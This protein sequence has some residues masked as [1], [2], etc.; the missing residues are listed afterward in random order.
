MASLDGILR[1]SD[2]RIQRSDEHLAELENQLFRFERPELIERI[3]TD[4][5]PKTTA[6]VHFDN[7]VELKLLDFIL[8][9]PIAPDVPPKVRILIGETAYNLIAAL[10]YLVFVLARHDSGVE[11]D[12]T[13][14]PVNMLKEHFARNRNTMLKGVSDEHVAL[15]EGL[16]PYNGCTW[17]KR[18]KDLSNLDKHRKLVQA[19]VTT[20]RLFGFDANA[21]TETAEAKRKRRKLGLPAP[22]HEDVLRPQPRCSTR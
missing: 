8:S 9:P 2:L 7:E 20:L 14:F 11:Q 12:G 16:Q 5:P 6:S 18:L 19:R 22:S 15:I 1:E 21:P 17:T 10:D 13:Q 4:D 3:S